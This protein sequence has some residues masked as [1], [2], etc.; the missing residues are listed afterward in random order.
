MPPSPGPEGSERP[1]LVV[2]GVVGDLGEAERLEQR[3]QVHGEPATVTVAQ[4]VPP[5]DRIVRGPAPRL[6]R[7]W[8]GLF[9]LVGCSERD[10]VALRDKPRVQV[11][12]GR[13]L[14]LKVVEPTWQTRTGESASAYMVYSEVPGGVFSTHGSSLLPAPIVSPFFL[15]GFGA[16]SLPPTPSRP[17]PNRRCQPRPL[18]VRCSVAGPTTVLA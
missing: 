8:P 11:L 1:H 6:D 5:T 10:P 4:A 17:R 3:R 14:Y 18:R 15:A 16:R 12:D 13:S 2:T 9:L 7:A